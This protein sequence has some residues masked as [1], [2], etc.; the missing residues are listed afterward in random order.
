VW[1]KRATI[2]EHR[3]RRRGRGGAAGA[4]LGGGEQRHRPECAAAVSHHFRVDAAALLALA[5]ARRDEYA[6]A[7]IPMLPVTHGV[8]HTRLQV[9]LYT[10]LLVVVTLMPFL[11][12]MSG[13]S[14]SPPRW[15]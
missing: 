1:L 13:S 8:A 2:A 12:R 14:T 11:T 5:I 9:L 4:R 15:C 3:H 10:V 6:R 7:G